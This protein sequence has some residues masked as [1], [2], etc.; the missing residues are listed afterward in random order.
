[1]IKDP[2]QVRAELRKKIQFGYDPDWSWDS[3]IDHDVDW[4]VLT[5]EEFDVLKAEAIRNY[6]IARPYARP[7]KPA[8]KS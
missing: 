3:S 7:S 8:S 2:D 1:M 6:G 4:Q 5:Q